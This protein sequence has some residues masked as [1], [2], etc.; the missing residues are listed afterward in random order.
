MKPVPK[1]N[2]FDAHGLSLDF[3]DQYRFYLEYHSHAGNQLVHVFFVPLLLG[4]ALAALSQWSA[5]MTVL[6][7][8]LRVDAGLLVTACYALYYILL[9]PVL[10]MAATLLLLLPLYTAAKAVVQIVPKGYALW[11]LVA[12]VQI[13]GWCA[14]FAAHQWLEK[15]RPALL[16][17][18]VQAF[19]S[20]PFFVFVEVLALLGLD[21]GIRERL[22][23]PRSLKR[24]T[25]EGRTQTRA[26]GPRK[27]ASTL[28]A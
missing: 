17:N 15:R 22:R 18:L 13:A 6:G 11:Y 24:S 20:A 21:G 23:R 25:K 2:P 9:S 8:R 16:D 5:E 28:S 14:Q 10:G 19:A 4:S 7:N 26:S 12:T 3:A 27:G 1:G